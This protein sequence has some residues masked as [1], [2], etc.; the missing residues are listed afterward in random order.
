MPRARDPYR[1]TAAAPKGKGSG[2]LLPFAYIPPLTVIV[3]SSLLA[4]FA[5]SNNVLASP[6]SS[7]FPMSVPA[8]QASEITTTA[9]LPTEVM[10]THPSDMAIMPTAET[11]VIPVDVAPTMA[12]AEARIVPFSELDLEVQTGISTLSTAP[13]WTSAATGISPIFTKEIQHWGPE[14][15]RWSAEAGV[16]P[17]LAA[18]VMQ[19][20]S[21]GD[22][23]AVSSAGAMGLFQVMPFHFRAGENGY[24]P[25][26]NALRGLNYLSRSLAAASG[27]ARL[28]LAG[29]NGGIGVISRGEWTWHAQTHRYVQYGWPIYR[30]ALNGDTS[31]DSV[32]EWY[33]RY[34]ASL[35]RQASERLGLE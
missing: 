14:I 10:P 33:S 11:V 19:I 16:D 21:C 4:T 2:C 15:V 32:Q 7:T 20:E 8:T 26:T 1:Q 3:I 17:N 30:D 23:R 35:C 31:S 12:I 22:P 29:Y 34:G 28:A 13:M 9:L 25:D 6:G 24:N 18:T 27:D 5:W